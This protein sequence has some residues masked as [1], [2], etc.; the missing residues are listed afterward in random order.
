MNTHP[1][2]RRTDDA[3]IPENQPIGSP[4]LTV[5]VFANDSDTGRNGEV[6]YRL[7]PTGVDDENFAV[8]TTSGVITSVVEFDLEALAHASFSLIVNAFDQ[9]VP[10]LTGT[11]TVTIN[12]KDQNDNKPVISIPP[13]S[14]YNLQ[15]NTPIG[16]HVT[17]VRASDAD[18][19]DNNSKI[20]YGIT[21]VSRF[22]SID[23][24]N[25]SVTVSSALESGNCVV[26]V[27]ASD[28]G[29]PPKTDEV[30]LRMIVT[31]V[32]TNTA[33]R[34]P[35]DETLEISSRNVTRG[36]TV[37]TIE[38]EDPDNGPN[39][40]RSYSLKSQSGELSHIFSIDPP[41]GR[42]YVTAEVPQSKRKTKTVIPRRRPSEE[43]DLANATAAALS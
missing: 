32:S 36:P 34:C 35:V 21:S 1:Y 40:E 18:R 24:T 10:T 33:P 14:E 22:V 31:K 42:I 30:T 12:I 43:D 17:T 13:D 8:H 28:H 41:T 19:S 38:A 15:S 26:R 37:A 29:S 6:R 25:G 11:A 16:F 3:T 4:I 7:L 27:S 39:G 2:S 23:A 9:G 20:I 5:L